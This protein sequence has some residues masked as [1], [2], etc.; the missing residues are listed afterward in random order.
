[1]VKSQVDPETGEI[2]P[3]FGVI[4]D[5]DKFYKKYQTNITEHDAIYVI[6]A[7]IPI[8][9][10]I[11]SYIQTQISSGKVKFLIDEIQ[12]K[13]KLKATKMGA[14]MDA[15]KIAEILKPFV[16]T[17]IL[18]T[19]MLNLVEENEGV[20]IILKQST[21]AIPK[22]KFSAFG[23]GMYYIKLDEEKMKKRKKIDLSD[24]LLMN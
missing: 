14:T 18:R 11:Y 5:P 22:D 19:Q 23:Y 15:D 8:N 1:M 3:D 13:T 24:F 2:L 16:Y 4:N 12:A 6:K 17:T 10:E 9:S 20:N 7:N 21:R